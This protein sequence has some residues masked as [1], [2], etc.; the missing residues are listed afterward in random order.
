MP[1][2]ASQEIISGIIY[3]TKQAK[4]S[5]NDCLVIK[6]T[7]MCFCLLQFAP[8]NIDTL[9]KDGKSKTVSVIPKYKILLIGLN[10]VTNK[11]LH[12]DNYLKV[13]HL[14]M[15]WGWGGGWQNLILFLHPIPP[16]IVII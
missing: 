10:K 8:Q 7:I 14:K 12:I 5:Q 6:W 1:F 11:I 3:V 15:L 4:F 16:I 13:F 9:C 2:L